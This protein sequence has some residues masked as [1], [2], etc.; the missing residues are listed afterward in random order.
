MFVNCDLIEKIQGT[1]ASSGY[2]L[3]C[4]CFTVGS[5][6]NSFTFSDQLKKTILMPRRGT[7][8]SAQRETSVL[9]QLSECNHYLHN[10]TVV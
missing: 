4:N 2:L 1:M 10:G 6:F 9:E 8:C 5:H 7:H 3:S